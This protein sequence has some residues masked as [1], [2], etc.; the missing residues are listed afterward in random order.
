MKRVR[1]TLSN[2]KEFY[3]DEHG[4]P[5][6]IY[7]IVNWQLNPERTIQQIK[8]GSYNATTST[9]GIFTI[10]TGALLWH[11][12]E[13]EVPESVCSKSCPQGFRKAIKIREPLCCFQCVLC[14]LG[15]VS[16]QTDAFECFKC[17][18]DKWPD[19]Q[20][21]KCVPKTEDYLSYLEPLGTILTIVNIASSLVP[22]IVLRILTLKKSSALVKASN[23]SVSCLLLVALSLCFL[24]SLLFIGYPTPE[25]CLFRQAAFGMAFVLCISCILAK[26]VMVLF[27]FMAIKPRS[28]MKKWTNTGVSYFIISV[29]FILQFLLCI[30]WLSLR[31]PFVELNIHT[32]PGFIIVE[33]NEGSP[34]AFW[35]MLTYLFLLATISFLVAFLVRRLPDSFNEAQFIT[36]SMLAFLC[37][38][39]SFIPASLSSQGK[40]AVAMEIFAIMASSWAI[41][42]C[43]F[44]PKCFIILFRP[45]RN[46]KDCIMK[47]HRHAVVKT[48]RI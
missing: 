5:P 2:G 17:P 14:P 27:A 25:K 41:L 45:D 47:R 18:W 8:V 24:C 3:F 1:V 9:D 42:T 36:F 30:T 48:C 29:C 4:D 32:N 34:M 26:T 22:Y 39:L 7:D 20:K 38:W 44:L 33:C 11:N 6:P 15:E 35:S 37:V 43:M 28:H 10:K 46:S 31:P 40:Y 19:P 13:R 12:G 23:Y 16:S 21:T